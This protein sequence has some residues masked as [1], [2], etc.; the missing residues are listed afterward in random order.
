MMTEFN[1]RHCPKGP[2]GPIP[3][4]LCDYCQHGKPLIKI[5]KPSDED[6]LKVWIDKQGLLQIRVDA[7]GYAVY[8]TVLDNEGKKLGICP[9]CGTYLPDSEEDD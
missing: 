3:P 4:F 5:G 1:K 9:I 8:D 7:M 6:Y 2:R